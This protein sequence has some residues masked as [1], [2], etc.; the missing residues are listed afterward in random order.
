MANLIIRDNIAA[1]YS[2]ENG[3]I[4]PPTSNILLF[5]NTDELKSR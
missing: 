5:P 1:F 4:N 2:S 3:F